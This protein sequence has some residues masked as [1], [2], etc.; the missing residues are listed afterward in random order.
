[1]SIKWSPA[2]REPGDYV[3]RWLLQRTSLPGGVVSGL[4]RPRLLAW[5]GGKG[6]SAFNREIGGSNPLAS[7]N[8]PIPLKG[9]ENHLLPE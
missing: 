9:C 2:N 5:T 4:P 6:H 3:L 8:G 7:A 1:M